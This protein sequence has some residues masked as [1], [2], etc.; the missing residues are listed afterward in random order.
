MAALTVRWGMVVVAVAAVVVM[1]MNQ[2]EAEDPNECDIGDGNDN[3]T[4]LVLNSDGCYK[5]RFGNVILSNGSCEIKLEREHVV[6]CTETGVCSGPFTD[7]LHYNNSEGCNDAQMKYN[8]RPKEKFYFF[9]VFRTNK[10]R[11]S[12]LNI[13]EVTEQMTDKNIRHIFACGN[14]PPPA[15]LGLMQHQKCR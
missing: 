9:G 1:T 11:I 5:A 15:C 14:V 2:V 13:S 10:T 8:N 4:R 6:F 12:V 3:L 7:E